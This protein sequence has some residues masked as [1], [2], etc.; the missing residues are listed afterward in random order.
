MK[1]TFRNAAV[2]LGWTTLAL[3]GLIEPMVG[4]GKHLALYHWD[5]RPSAMFG[6]VLF[7]FVL[8]WLCVAG[9]LLSARRSGRWR[10]LVCG[11]MMFLVPWL[12]V[13]AVDQVFRPLPWLRVLT[14]WIGTALLTTLVFAW[15]PTMQTRF[16]KAWERTS[17][18]LLLLAFSGALC[19]VQLGSFWWS[20]RDL[21]TPVR[22]PHTA[23]A[24]QAAGVHRGRVIWIVLTNSPIGSCWSIVIPGCKC[25]PL[26][27]L[28]RN[29]RC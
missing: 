16:E 4:R 10:V 28:Q 19:L 26:T 8:A 2:A 21:N 23:G 12:L 29:P 25:L 27:R 17:N 18:G 11:T 7:L 15:R 5:G 24:A 14:F 20:A 3:T 22:G 13:N 1:N 6:P 9:L